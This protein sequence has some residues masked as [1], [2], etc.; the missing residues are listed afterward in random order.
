MLQEQLTFSRHSGASFRQAFLH[1]F[2]RIVDGQTLVSLGV[3][4]AIDVSDGLLADL[5]HI[6]QA[7]RVG[8]R[9]NVE[10]LPVH[11]DVAASFGEESLE[12]ALSG[13]EDYELLFT[14]ST[15]VIDQLKAKVSC[16]V[17]VIGEITSDET[18]RIVM[19]NGQGGLFTSAKKGWQHFI[20]G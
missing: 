13:G 10:Q 9:I 20:S 17:T 5:G 8:A 19:V 11:P 2:P 14:A 18:G 7:S 3:K 1:P 6:C 16:P 15:E 4:A 12:L